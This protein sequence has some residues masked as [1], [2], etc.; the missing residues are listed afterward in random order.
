MY[1]KLY[2]HIKKMK[3][4]KEYHKDH[5]YFIVLSTT[6]SLYQPML[7]NSQLHTHTIKWELHIYPGPEYQKQFKNDQVLT[8]GKKL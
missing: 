1:V 6:P 3:D 5:N 2:N 7:L 4:K 8:S